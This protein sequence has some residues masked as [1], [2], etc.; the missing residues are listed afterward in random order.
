M[1]RATRLRSW[2]SKPVT[3]TIWGMHRSDGCVRYLRRPVAACRDRPASNG[4]TRLLRP[5]HDARNVLSGPLHRLACQTTRQHAEG[6]APH[7]NQASALAYRSRQTSVRREESRPRATFPNQTLRMMVARLTSVNRVPQL[8]SSTN[9]CG[10]YS[11]VGLKRR[12]P[13]KSPKNEMGNQNVEI[14]QG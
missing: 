10:V 13:P 14:P 9:H 8:S 11:V 5:Q 2:A 7:R 6:S 4:E 1:D 12:R 3:D